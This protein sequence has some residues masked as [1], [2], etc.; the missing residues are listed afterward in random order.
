MK[1]VPSSL[2]AFCFGGCYAETEPDFPLRAVD[3]T[4]TISLLTPLST[5]ELIIEGEVGELV[6]RAGCV[7]GRDPEEE[8]RPCSSVELELSP[9]LASTWV[10]L[11]IR[12]NG[13]TEEVRADWSFLAV[14][15]EEGRALDHVG[16][17][18][19]PEPSDGSCIALGTSAQWRGGSLRSAMPGPALDL[20]PCGRFRAP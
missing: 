3:G 15:V 13:Q 16:L 19:Y 17:V 5:G 4:T 12:S 1:W 9:A 18:L 14:T 2:A 8:P 6:P 10:D 11:T 7:S 20:V